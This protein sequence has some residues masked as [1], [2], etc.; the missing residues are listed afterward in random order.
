MGLINVI[1]N[2][3]LYELLTNDFHF[4]YYKDGVG[5]ERIKPIK[6][7]TIILLKNNLTTSKIL[8][9]INKN[10]ILLLNRGQICNL[11]VNHDKKRKV[12]RPFLEMLYDEKLNKVVF[13]IK[14]LVPQYLNNNYKCIE[15]GE[16]DL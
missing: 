10:R 4:K 7:D 16:N 14:H 1:N 5:K 12:M 13:E 8:D 2:D 6:N 9:N 15:L 3:S 11:S